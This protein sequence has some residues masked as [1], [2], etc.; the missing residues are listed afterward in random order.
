MGIELFYPTHRLLMFIDGQ[1][2]N[3]EQWKTLNAIEQYIPNRPI[4]ILGKGSG[5]RDWI[6]A[7]ESSVTV[8]DRDKFF[9]ESSWS[10]KVL[11][12]IIKNS[13]REK[14]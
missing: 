11:N 3:G 9:N 4:V 14:T 7:N 1:F 12:K 2:L 10:E 13:N 5:E 8:L 6:K